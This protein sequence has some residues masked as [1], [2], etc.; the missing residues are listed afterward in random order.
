MYLHN[1]RIVGAYSQSH[2]R[3]TYISIHRKNYNRL[4]CTLWTTLWTF[5]FAP[6]HRTNFRSAPAVYTRVCDSVVLFHRKSTRAVYY[7]SILLVSCSVP[8]Q[9]K[10]YHVVLRCSMFVRYHA[11]WSEYFVVRSITSV[12]YGRAEKR[13]AVRKCNRLHFI[14]GDFFFYSIII[15]KST[16][17]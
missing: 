15:K 16:R 6:F 2:K 1:S 12:T 9:T 13:F 7:S 17:L 5:L 14:I 4:H 10:R 11:R 3:C 8:K